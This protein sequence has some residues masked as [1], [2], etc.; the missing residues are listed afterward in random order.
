MRKW[1]C[2]PQTGW[3]WWFYQIVIC[4]LI[5]IILEWLLHKNRSQLC[6]LGNKGRLVYGRR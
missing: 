1:A 6:C 5:C 3:K 4:G 2:V